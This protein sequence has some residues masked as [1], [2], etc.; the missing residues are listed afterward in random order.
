MT[1]RFN[2]KRQKC[3]SDESY[4][5]AMRFLGLNLLTVL[6]IELYYNHIGYSHVGYKMSKDQTLT[7][8]AVYILTSLLVNEKHG[9]ALM[10]EANQISDG[11]LHMGATT[12]YRTL[13]RLIED[14][15]IR[16]TELRTAPDLDDERRRYYQITLEGRKAVHE[17]LS[18]YEK[19]IQQARSLD[20]LLTS[21]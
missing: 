19:L 21:S 15:F 8:A 13:K 3:V 12:L 17:E 11:T 10:L 5:S 9:Y 14:G 20:K 1:V 16:E 2:G 4:S 7:Q 18:R 6:K